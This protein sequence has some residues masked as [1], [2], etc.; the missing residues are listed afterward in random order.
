MQQTTTLEVTTRLEKRLLTSALTES[1][2]WLISALVFK[3]SLSSIPLVEA[4]DLGSH[5]F[6]WRD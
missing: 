5:P 6:S 4:L 2:S 3:D 1:E